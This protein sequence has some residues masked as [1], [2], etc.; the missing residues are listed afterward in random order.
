VIVVDASAAL[1]ALLDAGPAREALERQ[2]LHAPHVVDVEI[3]SGVRRLVAA[4]RVGGEAG[5]TVLDAWRRF[6]MTRY[7][8]HSLLGRV[9]DLGEN[10]SAY[11]ACYVALAEL[12]DCT[13]LTADARL[14]RAPGLRCPLTLVPG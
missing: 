8:V 9:W 11:D 10:V 7:P 4:G 14:A 3:A 12:L 6:G 5:W 1:A 13:L 2:Q